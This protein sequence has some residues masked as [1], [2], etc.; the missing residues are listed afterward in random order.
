MPKI[1]P[2][3]NRVRPRRVKASQLRKSLHIPSVGELLARTP[4]PSLKT[5]Q[6]TDFKGLFSEIRRLA[7]S[8]LAPHLRQ[9]SRRENNLLVW[10]DSASWSARAR[11]LLLPGLA[12]VQSRHAWVQQIAIRVL[13]TPAPSAD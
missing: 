3:D 5:P 7:G 11:Y 2:R 13:K 1:P 12:E 8:E 4:D 9:L 10:V 6:D